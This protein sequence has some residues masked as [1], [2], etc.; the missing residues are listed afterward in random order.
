MYV[1]RFLHWW[2]SCVYFHQ[3]LCPIEW[4]FDYKQFSSTVF[5]AVECT[6]ILFLFFFTFLDTVSYSGSS[7]SVSQSICLPVFVIPRLGATDSLYMSHF[8]TSPASCFLE[9][10]IGGFV[11]GSS[12]M[13]ASGLLDWAIRSTWLCLVLAVYSVNYRI[14][15]NFGGS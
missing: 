13:V 12:T 14:A 4:W 2:C 9:T 6:T 7:L 5:Y 8:A 10:T 1:D 3:K 11:L 15:G